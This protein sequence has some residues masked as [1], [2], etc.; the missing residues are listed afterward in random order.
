MDTGT[1]RGATW[2]TF[3]ITTNALLVH[4]VGRIPDTQMDN[5][6]VIGLAVQTLVSLWKI[7][8]SKCSIT[9]ITSSRETLLR[10]IQIL[11]PGFEMRVQATHPRSIVSGRWKIN[12]NWI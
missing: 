10:H 1:W 11:Q 5:P 12:F 8:L 7:T 3:G 2:S 4:L 6:C 9:S